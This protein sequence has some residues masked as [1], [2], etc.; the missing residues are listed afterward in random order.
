MYRVVPIVNVK[1]REE[2]ETGLLSGGV[3]IQNMSQIWRVTGHSSMFFN[4]LRLG[5]QL[6]FSLPSYVAMRASLLS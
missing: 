6:S 4:L 3:N 2:L 5:F 1:G